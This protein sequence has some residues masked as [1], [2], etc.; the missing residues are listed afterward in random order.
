MP[1]LRFGGIVPTA[2]EN[3]WPI[4]S[5]SFILAD[6]FEELYCIE[7]NQECFGGCFSAASAFNGYLA[8]LRIWDRVLEVDEIKSNM[9]V[10]KPEDTTGLAIMYDFSEEG[11]EGAKESELFIHDLLEGIENCI[12]SYV[13]L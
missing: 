3:P 7:Q 6:T 9:Y 10:N 5:G 13:M 11:L 2:V 4:I 1:T 12:K 8:N